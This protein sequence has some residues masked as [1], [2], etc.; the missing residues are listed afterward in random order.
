MTKQ[1][2]WMM[3]CQ[4]FFILITVK[5]SLLISHICYLFFEIESLEEK[6]ITSLMPGIE[7][8]GWQGREW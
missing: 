1:I 2:L 7:E 5:S 8:S 4:P 3:E 6:L